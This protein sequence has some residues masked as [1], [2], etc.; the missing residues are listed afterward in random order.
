MW[1]SFSLD[2]CVQSTPGVAI[3]SWLVAQALLQGQLTEH[4]TI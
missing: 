1:Q 2:S 4:A 3:I